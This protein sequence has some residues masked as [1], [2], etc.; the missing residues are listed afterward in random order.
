MNPFRQTGPRSGAGQKNITPQQCSV[1]FTTLNRAFHGRPFDV[2]L[3]SSIVLKDNTELNLWATCAVIY[4][5]WHIGLHP[6]S[7]N[8]CSLMALPPCRLQHRALLLLQPVGP[9]TSQEHLDRKQHL[10]RF[11]LQ[12]WPAYRGREGRWTSRKA[13]STPAACLTP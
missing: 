11:G 1:T 8:V 10:W 13:P 4:H 2:V 5:K 12:C 9:H 3:G 6:T 7:T